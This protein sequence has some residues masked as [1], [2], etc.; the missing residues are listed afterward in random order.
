MSCMAR[1]HVV[2]QLLDTPAMRFVEAVR[3]RLRLRALQVH[4]GAA[5]RGESVIDGEVPALL[6]AQAGGLFRAQSP[7]GL[8]SRVAALTW[9][10]V[11][12]SLIHI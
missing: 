11:T 3:N 6:R 4:V 9:I 8:N 10:A 1:L 12:L 5:L 2:G 7:V